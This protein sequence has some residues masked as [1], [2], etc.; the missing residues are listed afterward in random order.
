MGITGGLLLGLVIPL[1]PALGQNTG[2]DPHVSANPQDQPEDV[3]NIETVEI[4]EEVE[5]I[6]EVTAENV[7]V[8]EGFGLAQVIGRNHPASVH[9]PIGFIIAVCI[10][11]LLAL[12][13]PSI[14][15]GKAGLVMSLA[16]VASFFPAIVTGWLRAGELFATREAPDLFFEHRNLMIAASVVFTI[17][18]LFRI[19]KKDNLTGV[20]RF[21][22]LVLLLLSLVII[23]LGGHHG[24]QLVYGENFL[25]Y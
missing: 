18:A 16:T 20:S 1:P 12:L 5:V 6:E 9:L 23:G 25:P 11:E 15:L 24:G 17:S 7:A 10:L 22:Y 3:S 8:D 14:E 4:I 13:F 2:T 19:L 21:I